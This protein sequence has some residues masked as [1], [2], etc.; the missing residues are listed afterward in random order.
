[1]CHSHPTDRRFRDG[2]VTGTGG[3]TISM[4]RSWSNGALTLKNSVNIPL[5]RSGETIAVKVRSADINGNAMNDTWSFFIRPELNPPVFEVIP[6]GDPANLAADSPFTLSFRPMSILA[7][8]FVLTGTANAEL[9]E[10]SHGSGPNS[11]STDRLYPLAKR[12]P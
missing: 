11:R 4:E 10:P 6:V 12:S 9:R 8:D 3:R 5:F 2:F 7:R 1:M